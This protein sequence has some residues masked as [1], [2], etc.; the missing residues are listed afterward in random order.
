MIQKSLSLVNNLPYQIMVIASC[1]PIWW[2]I[3]IFIQKKTPVIVIFTIWIIGFSHI[4]GT[5]DAPQDPTDGQRTGPISPDP[6]G[7]L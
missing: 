6:K 1:T 7:M 3:I 4:E 2:C 5:P